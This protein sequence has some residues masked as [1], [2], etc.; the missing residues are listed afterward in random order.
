MRRKSLLAPLQRLFDD[1]DAPPYELP[2]SLRESYGGGLWLPTPL[3]YSNFVASVDG[4]VAL[5]DAGESG[6]IISGDNEADRFVM[7]LLRALADAVLIGAGTFRMTPR[8]VWDAPHIFPEQAPAFAELRTQLGLPPRPLL[9][10]LSSSGNLDASGPALEHSLVVTSEQ[11]CRKLQ[12]AL[13]S[14]SRILVHEPGAGRLRALLERL[15]SEGIGRVLTEGGPSVFAQLLAEDLVDELFLTLSP[16]LFGRND[17]DGRKS[18]A[19]GIDLRGIPLELVAL[20]RYFSH[21][22]ARYRLSSGPRSA[23]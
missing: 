19:H 2:P 23:G 5:R 3:V 10:V 14:G 21:L 4:V 20:R 8:A 12:A 15:R 6:H 1:G 9:V 18:V 16:K 13:P 7:G 22:F 11:G 17:G